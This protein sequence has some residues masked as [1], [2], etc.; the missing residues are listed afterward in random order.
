VFGA[1]T[2]LSPAS[3]ATGKEPVA[4]AV[5]PDGKNVYVVNQ[6]ANTISQYSRNAETGKLTALSPATIA[7][8]AL[9]LGISISADGANVYATSWSGNTISQYSR[10]A[11]TG[12]L[13]ALSPATIATGEAP[14]NIAVS[15]DGT[16]VYVVNYLTE[17]AN[18]ISQYSRNAETGKLTALSPATIA[19]GTH[20]RNISVS[21]DSKSVYVTD[22]GDEAVSQFSRNT[23]TGLLT[24]LTPETVATSA[25][26][27]AVAV[28]PDGKSVYIVNQGANT[29]SQYSRNTVEEIPAMISGSAGGLSEASLALSTPADGR[30]RHLHPEAV[31]TQDWPHGIAVSPD[32]AHVYV[33]NEGPNTISQYS[34]NLTTGKLTPLSPATV[35][36]V[37]EH[38]DTSGLNHLIV[39]PDGLN[40]YAAGNGIIQ[41]ERDPITGLLK[42]LATFR[43]DAGGPETYSE[44]LS[45]AISPDGKHVYA[46]A[47]PGF[48]YIYQYSRDGAG[49]LTG[50]TPLE[51]ALARP[52]T[53][54]TISADGKNVYACE[55]EEG[56]VLE[57]ARS[58]ST[59]QLTLSAVVASGS[60]IPLDA[61]AIALSP[62][63]KNAYVSRTY[64]WPATVQ[65]ARDVVTG[66]L[67]ALSPPT[68]AIPT[69]GQ[70]A[71]IVA[72]PDG[73]DVYICDETNGKVVQYS[74]NGETGALTALTPSSISAGK[75]P[76]GIAVSPDGLN[77]YVTNRASNTISQYTRYET[78]EVAEVAVN[79]PMTA[80][81]QSGATLRVRIG[82]PVEGVSSGAASGALA[83]TAPTETHSL[84]A[85]GQA[86]ATLAL[87]L[88]LPV[89]PAT[90]HG[91]TAAAQSSAT[92]TVYRPG[93][94]EIVTA[95][96]TGQAAATLTLTH[97][98]PQAIV[99]ASSGQSSAA[100]GVSALGSGGAALLAMVG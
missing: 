41:F 98:G 63:N 52:V 19:A 87:S 39:S 46:G 65:Y 27:E 67:S 9:P 10:N 16:G 6:G 23:A 1:L 59:G 90:V 69:A 97:L 54:I 35:E 49:L 99:A 33:C 5:S 85:A 81:G 64:P 95:S 17:G 92:L 58:A 48:S 100:L 26:P 88:P 24:A 61:R 14:E 7:T 42:Q 82:W 22:E 34:R 83:L 91:A 43:A 68:A 89:V 45:L 18:G 55:S 40:V 80:A 76:R 75:S 96:S 66:A 29:I 50:L 47:F 62:N 51:I 74:R 72:S 36:T 13:T 93:P 3:L 31:A 20:P 71:E 60:G 38:E 70:T 78:A 12:L 21:P 84:A 57:Y 94:Q 11:E 79:L 4:V 86:K 77:V 53:S 37:H 2:A 73:R 15:A 30:L 8:G 32:G 28:S 25:R 44:I 56:D